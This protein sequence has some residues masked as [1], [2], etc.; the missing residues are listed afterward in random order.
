MNK[1]IVTIAA[2][3]GLAACSGSGDGPSLPLQPSSPSNTPAQFSGDL[4]ATINADMP[5]TQGSVIVTAPDAA[6][7]LIGEQSN[8]VV[9]YGTFSISTNGQWI[10]TLD[11]ENSILIAL[12]NGESLSELIPVSSLDGT[13]ISIEINFNGVNNAPI[14]TT[15]DSVDSTTIN[16][17]AN[18]VSGALGITDADTGQAAFAEQNDTMTNFGLFSITTSGAWIYTLDN[19][20]M[21]V[22][23]LANE[24]DR[25]NDTVTVR[26]IDDT[27]TNI[28]ITITGLTTSNGTMLTKGTIGDN[29]SAP[30]ISC[31]TVLSSTSA[32]E[33]TV[34]FDM[35]PGDTLCLA[36]GSYSGLDLKFGGVGSAEQPITVA[37]ELA[38]TVFIDGEVSIGMTGEY[39]LLQGFIFKDGEIDSSLIQTRANSNSPCNNCR[40]TENTFIN[41]DQDNDDSTK[42][43]QIYGTNNRFDHNWV[44]GKVTRGA[45]LVIERGDAPGLEDRTQIDHN[46]FG[47][48]PPKEGLAYAEGSD[49]EYE[50]IR[51][52]SSDTHTSDSFAVIEHNYFEGIDGEA[53]V[54]SVKAGGVTVHH[55]TIRNSRGSIVSRHG[56]GTIISNNF[57]LGDGNPFS[58]GIRVVD[59]NHSIINNYIEGARYLSTNFNGG[60]LVSNSDGST[61]NG[62]QDVENILVANNTVVNSVNSIN[63]FAGN[64][65]DKPDSV[66][67]VNNVIADAIGPVIRNVDTLP[68]NLVLSGNYVFGQSF[69]DDDAINALDGLTFIDP[70]LVAD[71]QGIAR[72]S[73]TS[74]ALR[75]DLAATIGSF[76]LPNIDIDID[77]QTRTNATSSGSD[78]TLNEV[79]PSKC[80]T[81]IVVQGL[82][83]TH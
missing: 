76:V 23:A 2:L 16:S 9:N 13:T 82:G 57:I 77:G 14:F 61:S 44:S 19:T 59:A 27:S 21:S 67:F 71:A 24:S 69:S 43:I 73:A 8:I 1:N 15:G 37:A 66:Y 52:G 49:N 72:S 10:Y 74:P 7:S 48:R 62:Y 40:I 41:M 78:E 42:W 39:V 30:D 60:L 47:D 65:S 64:R 5:N 55:N 20:N 18:A 6:E 3:V 80:L 56:E 45:L 81:R 79:P 36:S 68:S 29:D 38:G 63:L 33:D 50:G 12:G 35:T 54:I 25:L 22:Q 26:S 51:V 34:S 4:S 31:T 58:G 17:Q 46:Y 70:A 11:T 75:A 83:R 32:L 53:E 28:S